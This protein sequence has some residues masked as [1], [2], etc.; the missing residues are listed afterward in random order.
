MGRFIV[1][2]LLLLSFI[3]IPGNTCALV[4]TGELWRNALASAT[5]PASGP[6][7]GAADA[8]FT[9]NSGINFNSNNNAAITF[10]Q[11]LNSPNWISNNFDPFTTPLFSGAAAQGIFFKFDFD[12]F[13]V[14]QNPSPL[15]VI[16]DD[17]FYF[18]IDGV[19][20]NASSPVPPAL[21]QTIINLSSVPPGEY[22]NITTLQY[23]ALND[24]AEHEL[25]FQS[26][27]PWTIL[28]LGIGM[29]GIGITCI[30]IRKS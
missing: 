8:S 5:N 9:L 14:S 15:T 21:A 7:S 1:S 12:T 20:F 6:P 17:G 26:P 23:G 4:I 10:D 27:E 11:F 2:C 25:I 24:S 28:L 16:H 29:I 22:I 3:S 30:M 18:A 19:S 13:V